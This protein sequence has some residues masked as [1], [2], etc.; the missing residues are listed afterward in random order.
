MPTV[1][2]SL[3]FTDWLRNLTFLLKSEQIA[4]V[5]ERDG[6]VEPTSDAF[7]DEVWEY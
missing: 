7:E 2:T 5:L 6:P 3:N 4:Y 1:L